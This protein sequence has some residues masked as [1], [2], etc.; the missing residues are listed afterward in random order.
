VKTGIGGQG[1]GVSKKER[2]KKNRESGFRSQNEKMKNKD[3][4]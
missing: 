3:E 2:R 4:R 1:S